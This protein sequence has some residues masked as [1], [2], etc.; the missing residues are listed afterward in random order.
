M[1]EKQIA[2]NA[3]SMNIEYIQLHLEELERKINI[4]SQRT[5]DVDFGE[6]NDDQPK[7][8]GDNVPPSLYLFSHVL[9]FRCFLV[10]HQ[11]KLA[12]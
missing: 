7:V 5:T 3:F 1:T 12:C 6:P 8:L 10:I 11:R 9:F 4:L 2:Y